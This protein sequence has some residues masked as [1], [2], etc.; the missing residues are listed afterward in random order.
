MAMVWSMGLSYGQRLGDL[1]NAAQMLIIDPLFPSG[2]ESPQ[3]CDTYNSTPS[4][5]SDK[6][7]IVDNNARYI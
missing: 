7:P 3:S 6:P 1:G 4:L 5:I 2:T